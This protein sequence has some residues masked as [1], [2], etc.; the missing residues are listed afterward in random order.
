MCKERVN[1]TFLSCDHKHSKVQMFVIL[2][3]IYRDYM[4]RAAGWVQGRFLGSVG[5]CDVV[6]YKGFDCVGG[7]RSLDYAR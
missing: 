3:L 1:E 2:I 7:E 5:L 4:Q 6:G